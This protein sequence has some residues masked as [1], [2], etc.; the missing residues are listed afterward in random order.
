[1]RR[2]DVLALVLAG[3]Q[4]SRMGVL[5]D[6]RAKPA[7]PFAGAYRLLDF[8]LSNLRHS[9]IDDVWVFVQYETQSILDVLAGGRAWDLDRSHGGL[10]VVSPQQESTGE[11]GWHAGNAHALYAHR[12]LIARERS[13][14]LL[15]MSADHIYKLDYTRVVED[16]WANGA[17]ATVVTTTVSPERASHHAVLEITQGRVT[18]VAV[19][20]DDPAHGRV[21]TEIFVYD[22]EVVLDVLEQLTVHDD[23]AELGDFGDRLLP[24]LIERGKVRAFDLDGYW[25]DVGRPEAYFEAHR[26]VPAGPWTQP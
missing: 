20:P 11:A 25:K 13:K 14:A 21:A 16:H 26:D 17:E 3:G 23:G 15:V 19:K 2:P 4:G 5:T 6:D 18:G 10:R 7:L 9:G 22:T 12:E 1:M 8:A 24:A